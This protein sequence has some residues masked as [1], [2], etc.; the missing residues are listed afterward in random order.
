MGSKKWKG[1]SEGNEKA[2]PSLCRLWMLRMLVL[3]GGQ[4]NFIETSGFTNDIIAAN[5]GINHLAEDADGE[6]CASIARVELKRLLADSERKTRG[7]EIPSLLS[8]N[9]ER[10]GALVGLDQVAREILCFVVLIKTDPLL[11]QTSDLMG[12]MTTLRAIQ[13]VSIVT[14]LDE[15]QV[16]TALSPDGALLKS[17]ILHIERNSSYHL[18]NKFGVLS[19]EF[20]DS[21]L[22]D[23]CNAL[24]LL[25]H[26]VRPA[27]DGTL[28]REDYAHL[29]DD[30]SMIEACL[31]NALASGRKGVNILIY[32]PP[33]TGKSELAR[34]LAREIGI[35]LMEVVCGD[36]E[37]DPIG[38][39]RRLNAFR[40]A[41]WIFAGRPTLI[42]FDEIEDVFNDASPFSGH[43]SLGQTRK[44]WINAMLEQNP[45]PTLWLSNSVS[46]L[47]HAFIRRFD[48][49]VKIPVPPKTRRKEIIA[50]A[51]GVMLPAAAIDRFAS[52]EN[53]PPAVVTR[54]ADVA[55]SIARTNPALHAEEVMEKL[56]DG[57]LQAQ[58]YEGV[59]RLV[60]RDLPATYDPAFINTDADLATIAVGLK[61]SGAGRIC[62][63]GPPGTG[64]TAYGHW[65][66]GQLGKSLIVKRGSDLLSMWLGSTEK[67]I[68]AAF[69]QARDNDALLMIDEVEGFLQDR[70]SAV[71]SWEVTQVNELLTQM[72]SFDGV[73]V[74][75][76]NLMDGMD[77]AALRRFDVKARFDYLSPAQA[78]GLLQRHCA[79]VGLPEPVDADLA[80]LRSLE[81]V[82]PGDFAAIARRQRFQPLSSASAWVAALAEECSF[83][84][85]G[86]P[87]IGFNSGR[88]LP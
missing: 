49:V 35:D 45:V 32:G 54:A 71:R 52:A 39:D 13:S 20:E 30:H 29:G 46:C 76:T 81:T 55:R 5:L 68:A 25:R 8:R 4:S 72:E 50:G 14:G 87:R 67:A 66:A 42:L 73:F 26:A 63:F 75:S 2:L 62:L 47:D 77:Q 86:R 40:T 58:G 11:N 57:T 61:T 51:C 59:S 48:V 53:L 10:L 12:Q 70:R 44:G 22:S 28:Q 84:E 18:D 15:T 85:A 56:V 3:G 24:H 7:R 27:S 74:A 83:K 21:M 31:R 33:G 1:A 80:A 64:K 34:L 43:R 37:G 41:Q 17:G 36:G 16:R 88:H 69:S 78:K 6:F 65:L 9:A 23:D 38:G 79:A 19:D 82:T 60:N